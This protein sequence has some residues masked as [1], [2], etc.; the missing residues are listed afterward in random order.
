M[1]RDRGHLEL[2]G[3]SPYLCRSAV[4]VSLSEFDQ[5]LGS[6]CVEGGEL[7]DTCDHRNKDGM[8]ALGSFFIRP[9]I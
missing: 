6:D 8:G 4:D 2:M 1:H 3:H 5:R 9:A 7:R